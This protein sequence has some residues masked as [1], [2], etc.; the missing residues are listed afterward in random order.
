M[1]VPA[2]TSSGCILAFSSCIETLK[3][4]VSAICV[5]DLVSF[6]CSSGR[7]NY[8]CSRSQVV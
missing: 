6:C 3:P 1:K 2:V 5:L 4:Q 8:L 7:F